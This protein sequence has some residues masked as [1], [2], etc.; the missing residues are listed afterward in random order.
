M[1]QNTENIEAQL[2][3]YVDGELDA[4]GRVEIEKH[5]E[6]NPQ[7]RQLLVEMMKTRDLLKTLPR[8]AAPSDMNEALQQQLERS[9]LL[10]DSQGDGGVIAR[11]NHWPQR[12]AWAAVVVLATGLGLAVYL[13]LPNPKPVVIATAPPMNPVGD[14]AV[15]ASAEVESARPAPLASHEP[16][17][18][19]PAPVAPADA[20]PGDAVAA[21]T[22]TTSPGAAAG[23]SNVA[24]VTGEVASIVGSETARPAAG[25]GAA[26]GA[27]A[28][29][30]TASSP[31]ASAEAGRSASITELTAA[32]ESAEKEKAVRDAQNALV[33]ST[34]SDVTAKPNT[35]YVVVATDDLAGAS[36]QVTDYLRSRRIAWE[37]L[38]ESPLASAASDG[39]VEAV[40]EELRLE[41]PSATASPMTL[42]DKSADHSPTTQSSEPQDQVAT[43]QKSTDANLAAKGN[44]TGN[45][46]VARNVT[47]RQA[48]ELTDSLNKSPVQQMTKQSAAVYDVPQQNAVRQAVAMNAA[49]DHPGGEKQKFESPPAGSTTQPVI[50]GPTK[51]ID[52][53]IDVALLMPE[54]ETERQVAPPMTGLAAFEPIRAGETLSVTVLEFGENGREQIAEAMVA[55]DGTVLLPGVETIAAAGSTESQLEMAIAKKYRETTG[56]RASVTVKRAAAALPATGPADASDRAMADAVR[57]DVM[58]AT[59]PTTLP[60]N[61]VAANASPTTLP[62][63]EETLDV[64]IV[65]Q[66]NF[67]PAETDASSRSALPAERSVETPSTQPTELLTTPAEPAV[68]PPAWP[69][70]HAAPAEPP[71]TQPTD[72]LQPP[73]T[74]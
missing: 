6:A 54:N 67:S 39:G 66:K 48:L 52:G 19:T 34:A 17:A 2:C 74:P 73:A 59:L 55:A 41:V 31:L 40:R 72:A 13:S 45:L 24:G 22:D 16:V 33:N 4:K 57:G 62:T 56:R 53:D 26:D 32:R 70:P 63:A 14:A 15:V 44:A 18:S 20:A 58:P 46:I 51:K 64:V 8:I 28:E 21:N 7:H 43:R 9:M 68:E 47:R 12:M 69:E 11:I 1:S 23:P 65:V 27:P 10:D 30:S 3:A 49:K 38:P 25:H 61:E 5:L 35:V 71:A 36:G 37:N 29:G 42:D 60:V 50:E